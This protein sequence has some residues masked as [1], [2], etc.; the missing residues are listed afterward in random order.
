MNNGSFFLLISSSCLHT[1]RWTEAV[2]C[3]GACW[4]MTQL[5]FFMSVKYKKRWNQFFRS[6]WCIR[7]K[8]KMNELGGETAARSIIN[9]SERNVCTETVPIKSRRIKRCWSVVEALI[10]HLF[11]YFSKTAQIKQ[12]IKIK[13]A[14]IGHKFSHW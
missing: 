13:R 6:P 9:P 2:E 8:T 1:E 5:L 14:F 3:G 4:E 7:L 12:K 10:I 11:C